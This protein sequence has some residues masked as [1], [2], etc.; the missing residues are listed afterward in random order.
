[1]PGAGVAGWF[2]T[3]GGAHGAPRDGLRVGALAWLMGHG[4][5]VRVDGVAVTALPLGIT[6]LCAWAVWRIGHRVGDSV[7]GHGPD[8]DAIAD[9]ERDWTVPLA[10]L[11][12]AA[13]YVVTAVA[14]VTRGGHR[15][16][17]TRALRG[18]CSGR[19]V[20]C[21][22][23]GVPALAAGSGRA[24]I[25]AAYR[26][27]DRAGRRRTSRAAWSS[28][29]L[30]VSLA[31]FV[32]ALVVDFSTAANVMGQLGGGGGSGDAR[33]AAR[34]GPGPQRRALH[35]LLPARPRL[36]RRHRHPRR[37]RRRRARCRCRCSRVLAA[38]PDDGPAPGLGRLAGAP[39]AAGRVRRGRPVAVGAGRPPTTS[40]APCAASPG[41]S[42]PAS[43]FGLAARLAGGAVGPGRMRDVAP[44]AFDVLLHAVTAFGVGG[45]LGGLVV[46]WWQR[47]D[48]CRSRSTLD[49]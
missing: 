30:L 29:W 25:W 48:R 28:L 44:Y 1:M 42:P 16:D 26:P 36:H 9:G 27:G 15:R 5:G 39:A 7:S 37:A 21:L 47:A 33:R 49:Q 46:T 31:A 38:L 43:L 6:L 2:L 32:V 3:D 13:G 35:R 14:T 4:S 18:S 11:L 10:G 20:L 12:F 34:A 23:V 8:A 17:R 45:L 22:V 19:C 41:A 24:A 40:R